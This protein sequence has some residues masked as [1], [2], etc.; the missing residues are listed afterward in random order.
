MRYTYLYSNRAPSDYKPDAWQL[1]LPI[2][3]A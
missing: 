1:F 3:I 2:Y